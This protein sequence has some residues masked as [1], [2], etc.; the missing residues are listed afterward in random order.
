MDMS[1]RNTC[2]N[3]PVYR[4]L[5]MQG[6]RDLLPP[7]SRYSMANKCALGTKF[8][9]SAV[10]SGFLNSPNR[11]SLRSP[12]IAITN[13]GNVRENSSSPPTMSDKEGPMRSSSVQTDI[14]AVP[15]HWQSE[16][17]LAGGCCGN[18]LFTLP[19]KFSPAIRT[20]GHCGRAPLR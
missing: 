4:P 18:G 17:H 7:R 5:L 8:S 6:P 2:P 15:D 1:R 14:S 11:V 19:S 12:L 16:S 20:G 10:R 9:R 13:Y 3:P